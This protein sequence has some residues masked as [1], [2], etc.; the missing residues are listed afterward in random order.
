[1]FLDQAI[2]LSES[3]ELFNKKKQKNSVQP[4]QLHAISIFIKLFTI[5]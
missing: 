1:M 2:L 3:V 5:T 4:S